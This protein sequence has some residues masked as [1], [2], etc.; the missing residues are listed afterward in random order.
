MATRGNL[1]S[2]AQQGMTLEYRRR[3]PLT[4]EMLSELLEAE[5]DISRDKPR[6][7]ENL[8]THSL[9]WIGAFDGDRLIGYANVAWDG[10]VHA[11]LLDPTVTEE[12]RGRGIGT[13]LVKEV[14]AAVA[15]YPNL[16]WIHVDSSDELMERFYI[17]AGFRPTAAGLA[18]VDDVRDGK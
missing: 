18:W 10:G 12:Y 6:D 7:Y 15:E 17:P 3:P 5:V 4:N 16:E 11:F 8:L 14:L 13:R 9:T 2:T 1:D